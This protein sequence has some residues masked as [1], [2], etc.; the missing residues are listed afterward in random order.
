MYIKTKVV[1]A[2]KPAVIIND[3]RVTVASVNML[4]AAGPIKSTTRNSIN[5]II[6]VNSI[7]IFKRE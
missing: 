5:T 6:K 4:S 7:T 3:P 1:L 2:I